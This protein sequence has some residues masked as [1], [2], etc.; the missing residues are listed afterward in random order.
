MVAR[1]RGQRVI[2]PT[3]LTDLSKTVRTTERV[4]I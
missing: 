4:T 2:S 1:D 3:P